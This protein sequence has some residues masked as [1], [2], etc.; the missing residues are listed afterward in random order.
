M[1]TQTWSAFLTAIAGP[2]AGVPN[3]S[4]IARVAGVSTATVS[5]W[6]SGEVQ[7]KAEQVIGV[8][9]AYGVSPFLALVA[10]GYLRPG[11]IEGTL[12]VPRALQ[13]T[14]FTDLEIARE[15]LRR[16]SSAADASATSAPPVDHPAWA[17]VSGSSQD[18]IESLPSAAKSDAHEVEEDDHTP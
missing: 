13:I 7:P 4:E 16:V 15:M 5:R 10:A 8:A 6:V 14:D 12:S 3:Q 17:V 11:D 1:I 18:D 9:R 2:E